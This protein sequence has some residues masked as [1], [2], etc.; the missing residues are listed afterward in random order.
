MKRLKKLVSP[1]ASTDSQT[2]TASRKLATKSTLAS[3]PPLSIRISTS[4]PPRETVD[5]LKEQ[6]STLKERIAFLDTESHSEDDRL[7][8]EF[9]LI[10]DKLQE[11][12]QGISKVDEERQ[13]LR[14]S[15]AVLEQ[16]KRD[17]QEQL[18]IREREVQSLVRRCQSQEEKMRE[19][20]KLRVFNSNLSTQLDDL[21]S[22]LSVKEEAIAQVEHLQKE[23][24]ACKEA[25]DE[26]RC[27]LEKVNKDHDDVVDTL[28]SCFINMQKMQE[29]QQQHDEDRKRDMKRA[30]VALEQ[31]RLAYQEKV[32]ELKAE[33]RSRQERVEQMEAVLRDNMATSTA[34]R[35][36]RAELKEVLKEELSFKDALTLKVAAL[37]LEKEQHLNVTQAE[38]DRRLQELRNHLSEKDSVIETMEQ[39]ISTSM[40]KL[41]RLSEE[42]EK[43]HQEVNQLE[44]DSQK[45]V[46]HLEQQIWALEEKVNTKDIDLSIVS[47]SLSTLKEENADLL[48]ELNRLRGRVKELEED[49]A[50]ILD[51]EEQLN[52]VNFSV[53]EVQEDNDRI[54]AT[55]EQALADLQQQFDLEKHMWKEME[56]GLTERVAIMDTENT[57]LV[58][59]MAYEQEACSTM[60]ASLKA[61]ETE[62]ERVQ[63]QATTQHEI[64]ADV[65]DQLKR[66]RHLAVEKDV[67]LSLLQTRNEELSTAASLDRE[68][69]EKTLESLRHHLDEE[70]KH[71]DEKNDELHHVRSELART[72]DES[73]FQLNQF[74]GQLQAQEKTISSLTDKLHLE[75]RSKIDIVKS[76]REEN[77]TARTARRSEIDELNGLLLQKRCEV[78]SLQSELVS[79]S[80]KGEEEQIAADRAMKVQDEQLDRVRGE[81]DEL[82][83]NL[84]NKTA[85]AD[86][87]R[88]ELVKA[89]DQHQNEVVSKLE[90]DTEQDRRILSL[91]ADLRR[92]RSACE[93]KDCALQS[94][95]LDIEAVREDLIEKK[96]AVLALQK[97]VENLRSAL[98]D[99]SHQRDEIV[100]A[101]VQQISLLTT[102]LNAKRGLLEALTIQRDELHAA[103]NAKVADLSLVREQLAFQADC[104]EQLR[105][106][107]AEEKNESTNRQKQV[108][109]LDDSLRVAIGELDKLSAAHASLQNENDALQAQIASK[110]TVLK[111]QLEK[112]SSLEQQMDN[113]TVVVAQNNAALDDLKAEVSTVRM[114]GELDLAAARKKISDEQSLASS[115][116]GD[117]HRTNLDLHKKETQILS[118]IAESEN[119]RFKFDQESKIWAEQVA[120]LE[121]TI[122]RKDAELASLKLLL[123][124]GTAALQEELKIQTVKVCTLVKTL[125]QM[126]FDV[127]ERDRNS[128]VKQDEN[129]AKISALLQDIE[130]VRKSKIVISEQ[131]RATVNEKEESIVA[132]SKRVEDLH[133]EMETRSG[134]AQ[135]E[136]QSLRHKLQKVEIDLA[137]S[138]DE[139]RDLKMIDLKEA[140]E[141][142]ESLE[143]NLNV[144]RIRART[145][146]AT[147]NSTISDLQG[148]L[149]QLEIKLLNAERG[150]ADTG[151]LNEKTISKLQGELDT[152][153]QENEELNAEAAEKLK[154]LNERNNTITRLATQK[155]DLERNETRLLDKISS[156]ELDCQKAWEEHEKTSAALELEIEK[157]WSSR[158][159][160]DVEL[161]EHQSNLQKRLHE[162]E[163]K[164]D[165]L[166]KEL[167]VAE[168]VLESRTQVLADMV[169][170]NKDAEEGRERALA[171]LKT[172][173]AVAVE[174]IMMLEETQQELARMKLNFTKLEDELLYAIQSERELRE[175]AEVE[176]ENLHAKMKTK[177]DDRELTELEKENEAL[178]DK[179]RRQEA[180]LLRKI[181]KDKVLRERN[182]KPSGIATPARTSGL[183]KP[184]SSTRKG[185][186][187]PVSCENLCDDELNELLG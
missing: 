41:M 159:E 61:F 137:I 131:Y 187:T 18:F 182:V 136:L 138:Q 53:L 56:K 58:A 105:S 63:H 133:L 31:Q 100:S 59:R 36:E 153:K 47:S 22:V 40:D 144:M 120:N 92:E 89:Q 26:L 167:T 125:S 37:E 139:L 90:R 29:K 17:I 10:N 109:E 111:A 25:R 33:S 52:D 102:E 162:Y 179:V 19:S 161:L 129:D 15:A 44:F 154:K 151:H 34:L 128:R 12:Q 83:R 101:Q 173:R 134:T 94:M 48:S 54:Q 20:A 124:E 80:G 6:V 143:S 140:E 145:Q 185:R 98:H 186:L 177:R 99:D 69:F 112:I 50:F 85:E 157:Q 3:R 106:Q 110:E 119:A 82:R 149:Q 38:N 74:R 166:Q 163:R 8:N 84:Q 132:L 148:Q 108:E 183:R 155:A 97:E 43:L 86:R 67:Q 91:E 65:K 9:N 171:E 178:R 73:Q 71:F 168:A 27:R 104:T 156:L 5:V 180:F 35:R 164:N 130:S 146:E 93:G 88:V 24:M 122:S 60:R 181:Q 66:Q 76:L 75:R 14:G 176:L 51:M 11:I 116:Q 79:L 96:R 7:E 23:L 184:L 78:E 127:E 70:R 123:E 30:E 87:L 150:M 49:N 172:E 174:K 141:T 118:M 64:I 16:E 175:S 126:E 165:S 2:P 45:A 107:L 95:G 170:H 72:R 135:T 103:M 115:L 28:N 160:N 81:R 39:E 1:R 32:N 46:Q 121:H 147:S 169:A 158:Q 21:K 57:N 68:N 114:C 142:I 13:T 152:L 42:T 113:Y 55:Y 77:E 117:L 4:P 62:H